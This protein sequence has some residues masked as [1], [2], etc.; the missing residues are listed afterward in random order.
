MRS[1]C[2]LTAWV[3]DVCSYGAA[4]EDV[5]GTA[6]GASNKPKILLMGLRR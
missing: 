1:G 5:D 6:V 2:W 4:D 3:F